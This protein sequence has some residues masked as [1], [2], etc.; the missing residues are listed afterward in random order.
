MVKKIE[1]TVTDECR[2]CKNQEALVELMVY[3]MQEG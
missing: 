3:E 1:N 2:S